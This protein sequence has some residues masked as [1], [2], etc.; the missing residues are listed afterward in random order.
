M[1]QSKEKDIMQDLSNQQAQSRGD[2]FVGSEEGTSL[3]A[4]GRYSWS[5][6]VSLAREEVTVQYEQ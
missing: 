5:I 4:E 1:E 6:H 3:F 2:V